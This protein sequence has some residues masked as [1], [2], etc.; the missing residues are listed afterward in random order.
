MK[1]QR[2][3]PA[4]ALVCLLSPLANAALIWTGAQDAASLYAEANWS[5][6]A[7]GLAPVAGTFDPAVIVP[8]TAGGIV[9]DSGAGSPGN[10][11]TGNFRIGDNALTLGG[12]KILGSPSFALDASAAASGL[13]IGGAAQ[14]NVA[15]IAINSLSVSES[16]LLSGTISLSGVNPFTTSNPSGTANSFNITGAAGQFTVTH[17]NLTGGYN[18]RD[19]ADKVRQGFFSLDG[20]SIDPRTA[21]FTTALTSEADV[22]TLNGY[23]A[24]QMFNGKFLTLSDNTGGRRVLSVVPEP[25][26]AALLALAGF[27]LIMRRRVN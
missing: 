20:N 19:L 12:G 6:T 5:D 1:P 24:T 27:G 16:S 15:S 17:T 11:L 2:F 3:V 23:L 22:V 10:F 8:T 26:G 18:N 9:I 21:G 7:T 25:S 13:F 4:F 14:L